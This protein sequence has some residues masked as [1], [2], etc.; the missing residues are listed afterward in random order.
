[1]NN[2][3]WCDKQE[4]EDEPLVYGSAFNGIENWGEALVAICGDCNQMDHC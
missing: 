4:T 1:M 2:C 3:E